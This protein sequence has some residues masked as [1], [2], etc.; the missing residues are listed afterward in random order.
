MVYH[1]FDRAAPQVLPEAMK[2]RSLLSA[3]EV[4]E[5]SNL[6]TNESWASKWAWTFRNQVQ[7]HAMAYVLADLCRPGRNDLV[8]RAWRA[9]DDA[10][11]GLDGQLEKC[12][13]GA[14]WH[15]IRKLRTRAE[16]LRV[17]SQSQLTPSFPSPRADNKTCPTAWNFDSSNDVWGQTVLGPNFYNHP[18]PSSSSAT[19]AAAVAAAVAAAT[20]ILPTTVHLSRTP[21]YSLSGATT[22][23]IIDLDS[24]GD[25]VGP[26]TMVDDSALSVQFDPHVS[27]AGGAGFEGLGGVGI[28]LGF[29]G[30]S[31]EAWDGLMG[32]F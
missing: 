4:I 23:E 15:S 20:D 27:A 17:V 26:W 22:P 11:R 31:K 1:P 12:K 9:L 6:L 29:E 25:V 32:G 13:K 28:G 8:E 5:Y 3:I 24:F 14:L 2:S 10:F 19:A 30:F 7:W 18:P 16:S 21:V